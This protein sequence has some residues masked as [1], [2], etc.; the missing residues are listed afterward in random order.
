MVDL[1]DLK[2]KQLDVKITFLHGEF[3]ET[4]YMH[5]SEG[6]TV[7]GKEYLFC[8][9]RRSLYGLKQFLKQ[10]YKRFDSF[11]VGHNYTRSRDVNESSSGE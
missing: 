7:E 5:Q 8:Q 1:F 2:F 6:F 11:M 9:L 10:W 4:I 3:E